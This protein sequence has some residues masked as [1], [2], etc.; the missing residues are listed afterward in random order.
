MPARLEQR[1]EQQERRS[2]TQLQKRQRNCQK[3]DCE[4]EM[5]EVIGRAQRKAIRPIP[6]Q[7][8][9]LVDTNSK[10]CGGEV[11]GL[12]V[13]PPT[14]RVDDGGGRGS[15]EPRDLA[16]QPAHC[17]ETPVSAERKFQQCHGDKS[18]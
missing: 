13:D 2:P 1:S 8:H 9:P 12:L 4:Q 18:C 16:L 11:Y 17:L 7:R 6:V 3:C 14:P 10:G 15:Q 5:D